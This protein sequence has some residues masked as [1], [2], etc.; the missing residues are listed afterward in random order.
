MPPVFLAKRGDHGNF[1][2]P[3]F[4]SGSGLQQ[5]EQSTILSANTSS[6]DNSVRE[7]R[8]DEGMGQGQ[9]GRFSSLDHEQ[10]AELLSSVVE[11]A[12][13][14][15]RKAMHDLSNECE[16]LRRQNESLNLNRC[17]AA[18]LGHRRRPQR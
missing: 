14:D 15:I 17:R 10:L 16:F 12:T 6:S 3:A 11:E 7:S 8:E 2:S 1:S 5:Q 13:K 18:T 4:I 9:L